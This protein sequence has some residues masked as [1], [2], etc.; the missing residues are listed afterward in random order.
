MISSAQKEQSLIR[1]GKYAIIREKLKGNAIEYKVIEKLFILNVN[2]EIE[3]TV[4]IIK[5]IQECTYMNDL[6][7]YPG[8]CTKF[9]RCA[10]GILY[11]FSC[12]EGTVFDPILRLCNYYSNLRVQCGINIYYKVIKL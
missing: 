11:Q 5:G 12:P 1:I 7:P 10:N 2:R 6:T 8:D 3:L 9:L 4:C